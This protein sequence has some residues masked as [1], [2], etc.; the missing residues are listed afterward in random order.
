MTDG[1][2]QKRETAASFDAAADAYFDSDTHREGADLDRLAAWCADAQ[3]ALDV[4]TGAGHT[5]GAL[6]RAGVPDVLAADVAPAMLRSARANFG[7][8]GV[9]ADAERLP[10]S[11]GAFDAVTCRIAAHHFPDPETFVREVARVLRPGGTFAL[12]DQTAPEE[13]DLGAFINRVERL[14]DPTHVEAYTPTQWVEWLE[15][16]GFTVEAV[17]RVKT[18]L[19]FESWTAAQSLDAGT[20]AE[21]AHLLAAATP[22][23]REL[24][25]VRTE[26]GTVRSF[27]NLKLLVR[28]RQ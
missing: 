22:A 3:R 6:S 13:P 8:P 25:E 21:V 4:A 24:F 18:E 27:A 2:E 10:F 1:S 23:A 15:G 14:R 28:A 19:D 7:V 5:A 16:A 26:D 17:E 11:A 9:L 12:E 20:K